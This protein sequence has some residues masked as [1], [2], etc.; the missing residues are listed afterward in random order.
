MKF[1]NPSCSD[2]SICAGAGTKLKATSGWNSSSEVPAGTDSYG[3]AALPGGLGYSD[4]YF[5]NVGDYGNWWSA[6]EGTANYAY[7]RGMGYSNEGVYYNN[8]LKNR[9]SSVRCLQD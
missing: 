4:G 5:I 7:R 8:D 9:P 3:F 6:T 1:L 2:N